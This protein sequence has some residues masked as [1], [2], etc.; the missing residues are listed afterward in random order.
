[1]PFQLRQGGIFGD[2]RGL[3]ASPPAPRG[4]M[5]GDPQQQQQNVGQDARLAFAEQLLA[6]SGGGSQYKG[7]GEIMANALAASRQVRQQA[8]EF[9]AERDQRQRQLDMQ[10]DAQQAAANKLERVDLGDSIGLLDVSGNLIG[11][12]PKAASPDATLGG[13]VT[14]RG[15]DMSAQTALAG[16]LMQKY[17]I[18]KAAATALAGQM[19][20]MRGQD[21][22][23]ETER[24]RIAG[25]TGK[26]KPLTEFQGKVI[27]FV[28]RMQGAEA[29]LDANG[30]Y[31]PGYMAS[32]VGAIPKIGDSLASND[33]QKFNQ[34]KREWISGLLR[35][36]SGAAVPESELENYSKTY[37]PI[38]GDG[39]QVVEQKRLAR[40]RALIGMRASISDV[41]DRIPSVEEPATQTSFPNA[42][43]ESVVNQYL[44]NK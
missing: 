5:F 24:Y 33:L 36:D 13:G 9:Q 3:F 11:K 19:I 23:S 2:G 20:Q 4:G 21:I 22:T 12:L 30:D 42:S 18:D 16:Q 10:A 26:Q 29:N 17:S 39:P 6:G 37:F 15:Q 31:Q 34:A 27:G 25:T 43:L 44:G 1:M 35:L 8:M 28:N 40:E 7:F 41:A 14:M 38:P 32:A